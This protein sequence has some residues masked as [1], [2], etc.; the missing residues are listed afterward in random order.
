MKLLIKKLDGK[1]ETIDAKETDKIE[2]IKSFFADKVGIKKEQI[3]FVRK[4]VHLLDDKTLDFYR[5][6][7]GDTIHMILQLKG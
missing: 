6:E 4:G 1:T 3:R 5:I 7:S 2:K